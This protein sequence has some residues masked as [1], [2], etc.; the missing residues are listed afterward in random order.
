MI[1][2]LVYYKDAI[3]L[4]KLL[5]IRTVFEAFDN[6]LEYKLSE[7]DESFT[8]K[9]DKDFIA[10]FSRKANQELFDSKYCDQKVNEM[11][12]LHP[13]M[14]QRK[15]YRKFKKR[16]STKLQQCTSIE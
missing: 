12:E 13:Y 10:E 4:K 5:N 2:N 15:D 11:L 7:F 16:I 9:E 8:D 6:E 1:K 3:H 14:F